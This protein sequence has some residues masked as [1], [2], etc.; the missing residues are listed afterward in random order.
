MPDPNAADGLT[1]GQAQAW[2]DARALAEKFGGTW[3]DHLDPEVTP[4]DRDAI[5]TAAGYP[6]QPDGIDDDSRDLPPVANAIERVLAY[7]T[8]F[9]DGRYDVVDGQVLYGRDLVAICRAAEA[10]TASP[11]I[12]PA[13]DHEGADHA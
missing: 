1:A 2:A 7:V 3:I 5:F 9:G 10:Q 4:N 11:H 8:A 12:Q 13:A 6:D